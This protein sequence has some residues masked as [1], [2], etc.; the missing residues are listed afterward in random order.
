MHCHSAPLQVLDVANLM[1]VAGTRL[2]NCRKNIKSAKFSFN[3][4]QRSN[5][6]LPYR[7]PTETMSAGAT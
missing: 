6:P 5:L 7:P 3:F 4:L 1:R 2:Q